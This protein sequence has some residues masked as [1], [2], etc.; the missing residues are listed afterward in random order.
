MVVSGSVSERSLR[1]STR[2][3]DPDYAW[4]LLTYIGMAFV[5]IGAVDIGLAWFP[6]VLG[7]AEWEF[8]TIGATLNG[9]PLPGLGLTLI[10]ASGVAL[11]RSMQIRLASV[12]CVFL[13]VLL[14]G[15][16][17]L[18]VTVIPVALSDV[19][20]PVVRTGIMK[21]IIKAVALFVIYPVLFG[22][23]GYR[24]LKSTFTK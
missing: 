8:G 1:S 23:A 7:S 21:S 4:S 17:F 19:T 9:L 15:L 13:V 18:Y 6:F 2:R 12:A 11:G 20:N 5:V 14:L 10:L 22:W 3:I 16:G 24:G